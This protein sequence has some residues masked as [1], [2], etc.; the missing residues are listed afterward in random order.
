[1]FCRRLF[2]SLKLFIHKS[3]TFLGCLMNFYSHKSIIIYIW[4]FFLR[5]YF[6]LP[7]F[8]LIDNC[9]LIS[10][11]T[12]FVGLF[13]NKIEPFEKK[14]SYN[15]IILYSL[16]CSLVLVIW[17]SNFQL[18]NRF[19]FCFL[20]VFF[21]KYVNKLKEKEPFQF[22]ISGMHLKWSY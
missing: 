9:Y 6:F 2:F 21:F 3:N 12:F 4:L 19:V 11:N 15:S 16:I 10:K 17:I 7:L 13:T 5:K 22:M 20:F 8:F 14:S 1:M 18:L